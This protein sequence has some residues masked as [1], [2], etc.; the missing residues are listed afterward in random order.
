MLK[1]LG[2]TAV[3]LLFLGA[4]TFAWLR[5]KKQT[6]L[7]KIPAPSFQ[8]EVTSSPTPTP[9]PSPLSFVKEM[10]QAPTT[11][12]NFLFPLL[13]SAGAGLTGWYLLKKK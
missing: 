4:M 5:T 13:G 10:R 11:G 6:G 8:Q 1:T 7:P 9:T 2:I 12:V 3:I